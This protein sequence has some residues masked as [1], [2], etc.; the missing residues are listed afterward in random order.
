MKHN[1]VIFFVVLLIFSALYP[2]KTKDIIKSELNNIFNKMDLNGSILIL[3]TKTGDYISN[4]FE[5][6]KQGSLPA[7]TFK[8]PN[9]IIALELGI[10]EN[11][12]T[13]LQWDGKK[14]AMEIW[15]QDLKL[16]DAFQY[17]C[18]AC[19]QNIAKEIGTERMQ[20]YLKLLN[21][22]GMDV[23]NNN[24]NKFWLE[25]KSRINQRQQIEFLSDFYF[26]KLPISISTK[27]IMKSIMLNKS[28][29][30]YK[31]FAKTGWAMR[32]KN[33]IG[34]YIGFI[35]TNDNTY[36]FATNVAPKKNFNKDEF[37]TNRINVTLESFKILGIIK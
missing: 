15:E 22:K 14:R 33:N 11:D 6:Q 1:L 32:K 2:L 20:K 31:L 3:D 7:S 35:E 21:Y 12:S 24:I 30:G 8:I 23:K 27:N 28:E 25:G 4:N 16:K 19:Y 36:I 18:V 10:V 29:K 34:W 5:W 37:L 13:I 26:D 9:T 17:S